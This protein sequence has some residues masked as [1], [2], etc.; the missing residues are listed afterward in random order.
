MIDRVETRWAPEK[1]AGDLKRI[2]FIHQVIPKKLK[3][4]EIDRPVSGEGYKVTEIR[5]ER[6][7]QFRWSTEMEFGDEFMLTSRFWTVPLPVEPIQKG[8][9]WQVTDNR[10][11]GYTFT[12]KYHDADAK[13]VLVR[14]TYTST[15]K[16]N[17]WSAKGWA[18]LDART[19]W[20]LKINLE[21]RNIK[22]PGSEEDPM[23]LKF[24]LESE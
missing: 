6:N 21:A 12:G 22:M 4:G 13:Q 23:P 17:P 9:T 5:T 8:G 1:K 10:H 14:V 3:M 24:I 7:V 11:L 19:G 20:P 2:E 15:D 18:R 16:G